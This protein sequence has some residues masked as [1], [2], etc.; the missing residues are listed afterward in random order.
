MFN[1]LASGSDCGIELRH[2]LAHAATLYRRCVIN[3]EPAGSVAEAMGFDPNTCR[4]VVRILRKVNR[5]PSPERLA[6]IAQRDYGHLDCDIA[7]MFGRSTEW[8]ADV[9]SRAD[10]IRE[11]EHIPMQM[12]WL[13]DGLQ[14][15]DPPLG[16]LYDRAK[17]VRVRSERRTPAVII[18]YAWRSTGAFIQIGTS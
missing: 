18:S 13:C 3:K 8:S 7:E 17:E 9:R 2:P 14:P 11:K 15:S 5:I 12:E 6:V 16:E 10:E 4:G 1:R